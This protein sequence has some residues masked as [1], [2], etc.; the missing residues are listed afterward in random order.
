MF[1]SCIPRRKRSSPCSSG[2]NASWSTEEFNTRNLRSCRSSG[3]TQASKGGLGTAGRTDK[4]DC[5][6]WA[7]K[8]SVASSLA[9]PPCSSSLRALAS[10]QRTR[11][12]QLQAASPA[13]SI[14][15]FLQQVYLALF[16]L[17]E[18]SQPKDWVP[19]LGLKSNNYVKLYQV[20]LLPLICFRSLLRSSF[21][22]FSA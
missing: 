10:H 11:S 1:R 4:I 16:V 3:R 9:L 21:P 8:P 7:Q 12:A 2:R 13:S 15:L 20:K 17:P 5:S 22:A 14:F 19:T 18:L 6:Q